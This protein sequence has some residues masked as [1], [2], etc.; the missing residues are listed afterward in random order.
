MA[1]FRIFAYGKAFANLLGGETGADAFQTDYITD[2]IKIALATS[3]YAFNLDTHEVFSDVTNEVTGTGYTAGG[4]TLASKTI[5][6]TVADSLTARA[7]STVYAVGD[8][9]RPATPNGHAYRCIVAGTSAG[10]P[11][12]FSTVS[13][14]TFADGTATFAEIGRG[15]TVIDSADPEWTTA[16]FT[17]RYAIVYRSTG[18][19]S[20]S[21]L[22]FLL[23]ALNDDGVT[24]ENASVSAST[25]H[26]TLPVLGY[27]NFATP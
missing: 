15:V 8:I 11:P 16:T 1:K 10:A 22:L 6:Y 27:F 18:T 9:Y 14:Q 13:W 2:T 21:P 24:P 20:T 26:L 7:N 12:T 3:T 5:V 17:M 23:E 4:N 19:G 25:F